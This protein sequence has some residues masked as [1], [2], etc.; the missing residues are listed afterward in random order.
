[1]KIKVFI[2]PQNGLG[3]PGVGHVPHGEH[4]L[5]LSAE[6]L[7]ELKQAEGV[8]IAAEAQASAARPET[9]EEL[10]AAI[11]AAVETLDRNNPDLW[12]SGGKPKVEA[13]E[14]VLGYGI[15]AADRDRALAAA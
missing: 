3:L 15:T 9:E 6:V 12:T 4:E 7:E 5:D 10:L 13:V 14:A 1:M 8:T 11:R 2:E